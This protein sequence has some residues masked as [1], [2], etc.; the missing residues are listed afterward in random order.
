MSLIQNEQAKLTATYLN[1][2]GIALAAVGGIATWVT[3]LLQSSTSGQACCWSPGLAQF[4]FAC[5]SPY[6]L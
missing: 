1:G 4:V 5:P 6:I 3:F 2:I